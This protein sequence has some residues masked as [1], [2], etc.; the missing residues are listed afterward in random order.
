M[1]LDF[2]IIFGLEADSDFPKDAAKTL[3]KIIESNAVKTR[4]EVHSA[5]NKYLENKGMVAG[6]DFKIKGVCH[7]VN[8]SNE[9]SEE[10]FEFQSNEESEEE[11][12]KSR[13]S[14]LKEKFFEL[15][16]KVVDS[17][18][19]IEKSLISYEL[20]DLRAQVLIRKLEAL[21]ER[22]KDIYND[23]LKDFI[24]DTLDKDQV[25]SF[26]EE[27]KIVEEKSNE[28]IKELSNFHLNS[29]E[30]YKELNLNERYDYIKHLG[31]SLSDIERNVTKELNSI[32]KRL[33]NLV[34]NRDKVDRFVDAALNLSEE[35]YD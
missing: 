24:Q 23:N 33:L 21:R 22:T 28:K 7:K 2:K 29:F 20:V 27:L 30:E 1:D 11:Y 14:D 13:T 16:D 35:N 26:E 6:E 31:K 5:M 4:Q 10:Q 8:S 32:K 17:T 34:S 25:K 12:I 15:C 18:S 9:V 19:V 3:E